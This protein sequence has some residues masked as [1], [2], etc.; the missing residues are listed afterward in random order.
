MPN[1]KFS[2]ADIKNMHLET[3]LNQYEYMKMP[4]RLIPE[5]MIEHYVLRK[6][7]IGGYVY[8]EIRKGM[9]GLPQAGILAN[10]LLKLRL[11]CHGYF[12][13][14][15]TPGL[16]KQASRPIWFNLCMDNFGIKYIGDE[17]LNHLFAALWTETYE[18]VEDWRGNLYC[19]ICLTW[20]YNK[21][22]VDIAMPAYVTKQLLRYEHP[23]P[24][25]PQHCPYNPNPIKYGQDNKAT[26]PIDTSPKLNKANKTTHSTN[27]WKLPVLRTHCQSHHPHGTISYC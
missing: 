1:A 23:H 3:P 7:A 14:S 17:Y 27:R 20:N 4:L 8:M 26:D 18:I 24:T 6:K 13:L 16:W 10:K 22:Y 2:G 5:D 25:K 21:R 19:G 11:A 9:Y 15:H 12:E